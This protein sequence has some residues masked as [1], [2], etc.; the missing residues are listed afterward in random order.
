ML[1]TAKSTSTT[2]SL[3]VQTT[4]KLPRKMKNKRLILE[5]YNKAKNFRNVCMYDGKQAE[6]K[7]WSGY[8]DALSLI[9]ETQIDEKDGNNETK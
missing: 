7:Y 4:I 5:Q 3:A 1:A 9:I 2:R 6:A 8:I